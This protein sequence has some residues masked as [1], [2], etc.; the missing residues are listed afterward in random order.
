M[1]RG[2]LLTQIRHH[3]VP[4]GLS[5]IPYAVYFFRGCVLRFVLGSSREGVRCSACRLT[6]CGLLM[7]RQRRRVK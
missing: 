7:P 2:P 4:L 5:G 3:A 6:G 1:A